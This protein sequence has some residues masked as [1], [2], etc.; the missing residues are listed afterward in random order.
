[1]QQF[2]PHDFTAFKWASTTDFLHYVTVVLLLAVFLL[3]ELNPFY[4][5]VLAF[6]LVLTL[7]YIAFTEFT[8]DGTRSS[9]YHCPTSRDLPLRPT[10]SQGAISIY[11]RPTVRH[12]PV[13]T[14]VRNSQ[15]LISLAQ[16]S[17]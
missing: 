15:V 1:M 2:S 6:P 14:R 16:E 10:C 5:K 8:V 17:Y 11:Q 13:N 12:P 3:A 9:D 7:I 4:L